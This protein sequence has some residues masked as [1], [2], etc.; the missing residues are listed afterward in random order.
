MFGATREYLVAATFPISYFASVG[1]TYAS[2]ARDPSHPETRRR[3]RLTPSPGEGRAK[4]NRTPETMRARNPDKAHH[5]QWQTASGTPGKLRPTPSKT[6]IPPIRISFRKL[7]TLPA[8]CV[9]PPLRNFGLIFLP[10]YFG[11]LGG[12]ILLGFLGP[13]LRE[14]R[15]DLYFI[16]G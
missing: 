10:F 4:R 5:S 16:L 2:C 1:A 3:R 15:V 7:R 6:P 11:E 14:I 9:G 12:S 13:F 8:S